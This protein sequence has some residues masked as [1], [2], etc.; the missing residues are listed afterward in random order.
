MPGVWSVE[1]DAVVGGAR[2]MEA[3]GALAGSCTVLY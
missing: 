1:C 2:A 3:G